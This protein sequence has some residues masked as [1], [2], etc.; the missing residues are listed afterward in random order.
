MYRASCPNIVI[1]EKYINGALAFFAEVG[2]SNGPYFSKDYND[3]YHLGRSP[4]TGR[5]LDLN[6][7]LYYY[8]GWNPYSWFYGPY[9]YQ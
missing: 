6:Y 1:V 8:P 4:V 3:Y 9:S 7:D 2:D 5:Q